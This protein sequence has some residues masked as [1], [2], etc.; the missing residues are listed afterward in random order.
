MLWLAI[1]NT[2]SSISSQ[3]LFSDDFSPVD[4]VEAAKLLVAEK[5]VSQPHAILI[6]EKPHENLQINQFNTAGSFG[7]NVFGSGKPQP[8]Q[9]QWFFNPNKNFWE[10]LDS[11]W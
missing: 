4:S 7:W 6:T 2:D 8:Y 11:I 10:D 1:K 3:R 5:A 9:A